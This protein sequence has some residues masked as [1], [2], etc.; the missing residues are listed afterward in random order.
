MSF[1]DYQHSP[2]TSGVYE[3]TRVSG[4]EVSE[5][6]K[7]QP[8]FVCCGVVCECV[9]VCV[10]ACVRVCA[11][12]FVR[13]TPSGQIH[14]QCRSRCPQYL[15]P[16]PAL[17]AHS[18]EAALLTLYLFPPADS[19]LLRMGRRQLGTERAL[20]GCVLLVLLAAYVYTDLV[21]CSS[22]MTTHK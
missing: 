21:V 12:A 1:S 8:R 13:A 15:S 14:G 18:L 11:R 22:M 10:C 20:A 3:E 4:K 17:R 2:W 9:C 6:G 5:A 19:P 7:P 16:R